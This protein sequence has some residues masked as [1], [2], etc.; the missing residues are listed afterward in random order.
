MLSFEQ[1]MRFSCHCC[2]LSCV[3]L[4]E[5]WGIQACLCFFGPS[6]TLRS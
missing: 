2:F 6:E 3:C 1:L 5:I 4:M